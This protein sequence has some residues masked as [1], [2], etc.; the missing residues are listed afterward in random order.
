[1]EVL[2]SGINHGSYNISPPFI[3]LSIIAVSYTVDPPNECPAPINLSILSYIV[4]DLNMVLM[5][6][7]F[8]ILS[9]SN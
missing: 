7:S 6:L 4:F 3:L 2:G 9:I 1:M 5:N 8:A